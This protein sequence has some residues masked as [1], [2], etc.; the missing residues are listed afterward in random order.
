MFVVVVVDASVVVAAQESP[1]FD[2][3]AAA[4]GPGLV[5]VGLAHRGR[6]VATHGGAA[7]VAVGHRQALGW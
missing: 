4:L 3:G 6:P 2:R 5:V 1:F 7:T